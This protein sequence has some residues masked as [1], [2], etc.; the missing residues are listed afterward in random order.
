MRAELEALIRVQTLDQETAQLRGEIAALPKR[1][2]ALESRLAAEKTALE[3]VQKALKDEEGAR[4]RME[5]D[6]KDQQQKIAKLRGQMSGV[7]TNEEYRAFQH[8]IEFAE[9]EIKKIEDRELESMERVEQLEQKRKAAESDLKDNMKVVEI[10]QNQARAVSAEQQKHLADLLQRRE[11]ERTTVPEEWLRE[12]DRISSKGGTGVA[13]AQGQ[14][15]VSCQMGIRP[16]M[17]N[18]IRSGEIMTCESCGRLLYYDAAKEPQPEPEP[19]KPK[20]GRKAPQAG[21]E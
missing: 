16:Q 12:Y 3:Q 15:C 11:T 18:Q 10:E 9:A 17:W 20:R 8:E 7:K 14:R 6:L 19:E 21:V 4:R 1:L 13:Y 5:S 2:A